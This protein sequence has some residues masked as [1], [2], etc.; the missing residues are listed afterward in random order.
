MKPKKS[1]FAHLLVP[2]AAT[3]VGSACILEMAGG[4]TSTPQPL[5]VT[6]TGGT[7]GPGEPAPSQTIE[8]ILTPTPTFSP[9]LTPTTTD[10][11]V[12]K[13]QHAAT[14]PTYADLITFTL[15]GTARGSERIAVAGTVNQYTRCQATRTG[16]GQT[17]KLACEFARL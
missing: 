1:L 13:I 5:V 6:A 16:S 2:L 7:V 15:P 10:T 9:I 8:S 3:A 17:L 12:I 14:L 11:Y 4:P